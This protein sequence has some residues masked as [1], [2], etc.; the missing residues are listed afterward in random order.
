MQ[1]HR[2]GGFDQPPDGDERAFDPGLHEGDDI[3]I[4]PELSI[5]ELFDQDGG[6][7]GVIGRPDF[8]HSRRLQP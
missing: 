2:V 7:Q 5:G 3:A 1:R 6:Q 8:G 4:D